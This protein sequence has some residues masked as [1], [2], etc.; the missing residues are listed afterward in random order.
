MINTVLNTISI[1]IFGT[2]RTSVITRSHGLNDI[3]AI[4]S[5]PFFLIATE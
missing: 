2:R 5:S 3:V 4:V 1:T